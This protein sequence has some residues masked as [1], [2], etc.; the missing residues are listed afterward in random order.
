MLGL[1]GYGNYIRSVA[2]DVPMLRPFLKKNQS[3]NSE[4]GLSLCTSHKYLNLA[5]YDNEE[6][7]YREEQ[8]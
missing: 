1:L 3:T 5:S 2:L 6:S 4:P 7:D 8:F